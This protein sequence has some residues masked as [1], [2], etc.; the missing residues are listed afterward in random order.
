M[1]EKESALS[2][3]SSDSLLLVYTTNECAVVKNDK[4]IF[5]YF[6]QFRPF[7]RGVEVG[8]GSV[9]QTSD[10]CISSAHI[11]EGGSVVLVGSVNQHSLSLFHA[12][13]SLD[14]T[15]I[16]GR[17]S[18]IAFTAVK[19]FCFDRVI[20]GGRFCGLVKDSGMYLLN[21]TAL[22]RSKQYPGKVIE[23]LLVKEAISIQSEAFLQLN[24]NQRSVILYQTTLG[25]GGLNVSRQILLRF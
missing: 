22:S 13:I 15:E 21:L 9:E 6:F 20:F 8:Q 2:I 5:E 7:V 25:E 11:Y 18:R 4:G 12:S 19:N 23:G 14:C 1:L 10:L 17:S 3:S 24:E 16:E